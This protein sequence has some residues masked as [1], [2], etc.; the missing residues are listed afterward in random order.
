MMVVETRA[1]SN[2]NELFF[3]LALLEVELNGVLLFEF[4][5]DF[6]S[7]FNLLSISI[8]FSNPTSWVFVE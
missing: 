2:E 8:R 3:P 6:L 5:V 7:F 1:P 4:S